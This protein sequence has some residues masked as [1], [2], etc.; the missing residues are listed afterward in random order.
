MKKP[1]KKL[2]GVL[3]SLLIILLAFPIYSATLKHDSKSVISKTEIAKSIDSASYPVDK[4]ANLYDEL[5]LRMAGL[6]EN[7]FKMAM[8]GYESLQSMGK[9]QNGT[10]LT[11]IDFSKPSTEKRMYVLDLADM[12]LLYKTFVSH[13]RNSGKLYANR[14]S[15]KPESHMSSLGFYVTGNTYYG[16]HGYSLRLN[17]EEEG[18]N[19]KALQRAIVIH[20]ADYA[21]GKFAEKQGYLGRSYGCPALPKEVSKPIIETIKE[22]SCIFVY[23][24]SEKYFSKSQLL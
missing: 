8:K 10:V 3:T 9:I 17:G 7:V 16:Q 2:L 6:S 4:I 23:G 15:N 24:P 12:K 1:V 14:F 5:N 18:I 11:V 20:S 13:G 22:G 19:D 21:S